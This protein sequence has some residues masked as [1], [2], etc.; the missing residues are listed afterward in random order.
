[1]YI[2]GL[3]NYRDC[4]HSLNFFLSLRKKALYLL[5][6]KLRKSFAGR[7]EVKEDVLSWSQ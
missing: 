6:T 1:M 4:M 2:P 5:Q 3:F 7:K